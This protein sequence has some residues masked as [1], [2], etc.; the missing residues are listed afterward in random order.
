MPTKTRFTQLSLRD[1]SL[2]EPFWRERERL[3]REVIL[4]YQWEALN[5]RVPGAEPS[6]AIRNFKIAAGREQGDFHGFVFQDSDVYKWLEAVAYSLASHP[7]AKLE[8]AADAVIELIAAAQDADGYLDT[9]F[10]IV[11][12]KRKWTD[13]ENSHELYCAGHFFEAAAAYF[14]TTGKKPIIDVAGRLARHIASRFGVE[15][16]K[17]RGYSGH[18]EVEL[19]LVRLFEVTGESAYLD[20]ASYFIDERGQAPSFFKAEAQARRGANVWNRWTESDKVEDFDQ[21]YRQA[22]APVREQSTATGHAVR[23]M[24]LYAAMADLANAQ[25][26]AGLAAACERLFDDVARRQMYV[27]GGFG[28]A[29]NGERFTFDY[30]LPLGTAYTETCASVGFVFFCRRLLDLRLDGRYADAMERA[31][32]NTVLSGVALDGKSYF[33]VNPL[34]AWPAA[35]ALNPSRSHVKTRRQKWFACACCPPNVSRLLLSLGRYAYTARPDG[36][37]VHLYVGGS[38]NAAVGGTRMRWEV[39]TEY[40]REG[41]VSLNVSVEGAESANASLRLRVPAWSRDTRVRVNGVSLDVSRAV[42]SGYLRIEREWKDG[43]AVELALDMA[44]RFTR[45][46][47]LLRAAAGKLVLERGPLVYCVEEADVGPNPQGLL[48][49][50][51]KELTAQK[52]LDALGAYYSLSARA[53]RADAAAWGDE[54]YKAEP[55]RL[56]PVSLRA[57]PYYLWGNRAEGEMSVWLREAI[58]TC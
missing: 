13:L 44:P 57:I 35:S 33:Y 6:G 53:Y 3:A 56:V 41:L 52:E 42:E 23:A 22:H 1:V 8:A 46:N 15:P 38:V 54:L 17:A 16:G 28:S 58:S 45:A 27:T 9:Y 11:E 55:Y 21:S 19:A 18:E 14:E 10:Q 48:I 47:P 30:D 5:D 36:L 4:P 24:Y 12:P 39:K 31:L 20:L 2:S 40:P 25:N 51:G 37:D 26:D 43:D 50:A 34:E 29:A 7:D 49:D 32:Y